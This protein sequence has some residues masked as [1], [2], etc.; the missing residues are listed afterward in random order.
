MLH[1]QI[2]TGTQVPP[3]PEAFLWELDIAFDVCLLPLDA[4]HCVFFAPQTKRAVEGGQQS[5]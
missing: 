4:P 5:Q 1:A 2:Y 3:T